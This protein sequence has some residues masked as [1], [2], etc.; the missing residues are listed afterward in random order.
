MSDKRSSEMCKKFVRELR[1]GHYH[2][3][4]A[5]GLSATGEEKA[6]K[7]LEQL[8]D[9]IK[10]ELILDVQVMLNNNGHLGYI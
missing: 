5:S 2:C 1:D 10:A 6:V 7:A 9:T 4:V 8:V 3:S